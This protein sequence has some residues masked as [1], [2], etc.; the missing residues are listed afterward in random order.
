MLLEGSLDDIMVKFSPKIYPKCVTMIIKG[1]PLLYA[2]IQMA[3]YGVLHSVPL[4]Y[5]NLVKELEAYGFQIN[6]Y[7]PCVAN[8][9]INKKRHWC[10]MLMN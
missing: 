7:N 1:K 6:P 4:L 8:K 5:I 2:Q 3:L 10:G 9:A